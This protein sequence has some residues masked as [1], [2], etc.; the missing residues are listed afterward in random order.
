MFRPTAETNGG[1]WKEGIIVLQTNPK[2]AIVSDFKIYLLPS[3]ICP[4]IAVVAPVTLPF[5]FPVRVAN[6][7]KLYLFSFYSY[8]FNIKK[9][10]GMAVDQTGSVHFFS[11]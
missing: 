3:F 5:H 11:G 7:D 1:D 10:I 2:S 8:Y 9:R 6:L 4:Q